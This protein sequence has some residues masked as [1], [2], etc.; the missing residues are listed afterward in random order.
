MKLILRHIF[1]A[2]VLLAFFACSKD[3]D[4]GIDGYESDRRGPSERVVPQVTGRQVLLSYSAG[5]NDLSAELEDD[6]DEL[7]TGW[8]PARN[9]PFV[10]LVFSKRTKDNRK[11]YSIKTPAHLIRLYR[12][13]AGELVSDTLKTWPEGTVAASASTLGEVLSYV[14]TS[15]PSSEYGMIFSSH[16]TGWVPKGYYLSGTITEY[17]PGMNMAPGLLQVSER[18][19]YSLE[20]EDVLEGP[21]VRS[22]GVDIV[23]MINSTTRYEIN[24]EDFAAAI[25]MKL[26]YIIMDAC[27]MG[28]VEVA[29][30]LREKTRYLVFSQTEVLA[31]GLCNYPTIT[32]RLFRTGGPDLK[33]LCEDAYSHY[34]ALSGWEQSVTLSLVDTDGLDRLAEVCAGLFEDYRT[35]IGN[36]SMYDV[37]QYYRYSKRWYFDIEDILVKSG[38]PDAALADFREALSSCVV[39][40]AATPRFLSIDIVSFSGLSMY[41]PCADANTALRNFY[42]GLS[43]NQATGLLN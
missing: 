27:L 30:A 6:I 16:A 24:I 28:G 33:G 1:P 7:K 4:F 14:M 12:G 26:D 18:P 2:V 5:F 39:Y 41:L 40:K 42:R 10:L 15:F 9:S 11:D 21:R 22:L 20:P 3:G 19:V 32:S 31:D 37:Q 43:W 13:A 23:D 8:I 17:A 25:P 29:Y 35:E 36:V 38:V 34:S